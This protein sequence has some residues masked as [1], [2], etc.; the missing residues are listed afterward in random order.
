MIF[1]SG[2]NK[3]ESDV[4]K[5]RFHKKGSFITNRRVPG[6]VCVEEEWDEKKET[7]S[8]VTS[9]ALWNKIRF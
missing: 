3:R 4:K 5:I 6:H 9:G 7:R 8:P 1:L 2:T